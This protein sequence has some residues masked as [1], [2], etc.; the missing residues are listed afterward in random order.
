MTTKL[1]LSAMLVPLVLLGACST[2]KLAQQNTGNDDIYYS[3][4][5]AKEVD[6]SQRVNQERSYRTDEQLYGDERSQ[7]DGYYD[8]SYASRISR[9]YYDSPWRGYYDNWY[10]YY[11]Y[12]P[13]Y[14][15][16][17]SPYY[18]P[19]WSFNIGIGLGWGSPYYGLYDYY[20]PYGYP[21]RWGVYSYYRPY[22]GY[23]GGYGGYYGGYPI[24][25]SP[26]YS[27]PNYRPRPGGRTGE[28]Y[29]GYSRGRTTIYGGQPRGSSTTN[30]RGNSVSSGSSNGRTNQPVSRP[31]PSR[32]TQNEPSRTET[33]PSYQPSPSSSS[34]RGSSYGGGGSSSGGSSRPRP[35]R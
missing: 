33:R 14:D 2:N 12:D 20:Y 19:G 22:G 34:G 27:S 7:Y 24:Y 30:P 10:N 9:F 25:G 5:K 13:F 28:S 17:Y 32:D 29:G 21:Y 1:K 3:S 18:R 23:W 35:S 11:S 6:Y 15:G 4:A 26:V 31:R 8:D 16:F